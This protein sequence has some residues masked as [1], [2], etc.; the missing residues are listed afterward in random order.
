MLYSLDSHF[1]LMLLCFRSGFSYGK[2]TAIDLMHYLFTGIA[3]N[4]VL[5][6]KLVDD[7]VLYAFFR[8]FV[9]HTVE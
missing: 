6:V 3:S 7:T 4:I 9:D 8:L 2:S 1:A 5:H